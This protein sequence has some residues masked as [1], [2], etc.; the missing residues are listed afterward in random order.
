MKVSL[1][2]LMQ[3]QTLSKYN[4]LPLRRNLFILVADMLLPRVSTEL[5]FY[6]TAPDEFAIA[7]LD[8]VPHSGLITSATAEQA[9]AI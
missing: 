5:A 1:S 8:H 9:T 4:C 2:S 3:Y 7:F 6:V